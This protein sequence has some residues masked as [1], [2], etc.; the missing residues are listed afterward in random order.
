MFKPV[1]I[2]T[3]FQR[4]KSLILRMLAGKKLHRAVRSNPRAVGSLGVMKRDGRESYLAGVCFPL[5]VSSTQHF[6]SDFRAIVVWLHTLFMGN[7]LHNRHFQ[8]LWVHIVS[9]IE[10]INVCIKMCL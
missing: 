1:R 9:W 10:E 2:G 8:V 4:S 7:K 6:I 5:W 3:S